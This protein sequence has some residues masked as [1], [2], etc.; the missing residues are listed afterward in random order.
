MKNKRAQA[1]FLYYQMDEQ[2]PKSL[3]RKAYVCFKSL[4]FLINIFIPIEKA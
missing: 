4:N 3:K 1:L 2:A